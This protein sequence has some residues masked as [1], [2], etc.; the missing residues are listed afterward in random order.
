MTTGLAGLAL[1]ETVDHLP[2]F[3][4]LP[5]FEG[6]LSAC[7]CGWVILVEQS[8][9]DPRHWL[10]HLADPAAVEPGTMRISKPGLCSPWLR[11]TRD[12]PGVPPMLAR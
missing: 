12:T 2:D 9:L 3:A 7:S 6:A 10:R 1:R 4:Y 8:Y 11:S 5:G